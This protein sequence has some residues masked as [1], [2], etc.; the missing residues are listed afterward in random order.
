M[1][2]SKRGKRRRWKGVSKWK[3][4]GDRLLGLQNKVIILL[5]TILS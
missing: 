1:R 2:K 4:E 5:K 3:D